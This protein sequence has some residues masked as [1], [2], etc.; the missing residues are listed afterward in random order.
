MRV[1]LAVDC[2]SATLAAE[3]ARQLRARYRDRG[4]VDVRLRARDADLAVSQLC[5][6]IRRHLELCPPSGRRVELDEADVLNLARHVAM[7]LD[8]Y[9]RGT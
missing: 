7:C 5:E 6:C 8:E 2:A 9:G 1:A 4:R 3:V